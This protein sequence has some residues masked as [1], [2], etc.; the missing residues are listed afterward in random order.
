M[1]KTI[2]MA[3]ASAVLQNIG[4]FTKLCI[5]YGTVG[6]TDGASLPGCSCSLATSLAMNISVVTGAIS[7]EIR[8]ESALPV[9][10]L[11]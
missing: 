7:V 2:A 9:N 5:L 4:L 8:G 11:E 10:L 6:S 3:S 1:Q